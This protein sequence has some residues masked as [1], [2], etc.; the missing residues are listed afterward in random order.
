MTTHPYRDGHRD[1]GRLQ[2]QGQ[3]RSQ[4][5]DQGQD[6]S[7]DGDR[8]QVAMEYLGFLPL[9]LLVAMAAIQ[10]G[11]AAYAASQA[12]TASRAG[13]RTAASVDARG[14]GQTNA[15]D[16]VSDWV[17]EGGFRYRQ[18]GGQDITVTVRVKVPSVVPGLDDWWAERSTTMPNEK[19]R[20][21]F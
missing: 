21:G 9:L 10:L 12:G 2:D 16:A 5:R 14:S 20:I 1:L 17:E 18:R 4:E 19:S 11:L 8:G 13:A 6:R 3:D 15:R 7:Q